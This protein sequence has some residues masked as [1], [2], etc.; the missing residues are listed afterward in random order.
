MKLNVSKNLRAALMSAA[1]AVSATAPSFAAVIPWGITY[2]EGCQYATVGG[3]NL[4]DF[5]VSGAWNNA[6]S[7]VFSAD[8][9]SLT[10]TLNLLGVKLDASSLA[11]GVTMADGSLKLSV[12]GNKDGTDS[13]SPEPVD[14]SSRGNITFVLSRANSNNNG[15]LS[16]KV[17]DSA[18]F[19]KVLYELESNNAQNSASGSW[20]GVVFGGKGSYGVSTGVSFEENAGSYHLTKAGY[21]YEANASFADL[22]NYY[23]GTARDNS[24]TW[25][26]SGGNNWSDASWTTEGGTSGQ[27]ITNYDSVTFDTAGASVEL[28]GTTSVTAATVSED[29]AFNLHGHRLA[30]DSL[31]VGSGKALTVS[32]GGTLAVLNSVS[33]GTIDA[34]ASSV[35]FRGAEIADTTIKGELTLTGASAV[36]LNGTVTFD[37]VVNDLTYDRN[38]YAFTSNTNVVALKFTG[39]SDLTRNSNGAA[40]NISKILLN[41]N[42]SLTVASGASLK[43]SAIFNQYNYDSDDNG[44]LTVEAGGRLELVGGGDTKPNS[45]VKWLVNEGAISSTQDFGSHE[46]IV[47]NGSL[48]VKNLYIYNSN[49]TTSTLGG[50]V[51]ATILELHGGTANVTGTVKATNHLAL[52]NGTTANVTG[53]MTVGY[54]AVNSGTATLSGD[55]NGKLIINYADD[56][57]TAHADLSGSFGIE[58]TGGVAQTFSGHTSGYSGKIDISAGTLN[59]LQMGANSKVTEITISGGS[60]LGLYKNTDHTATTANE[61]TVTFGHTDDAPARGGIL[62]VK[63]GGGN[64]NAN[65]VLNVGSILDMDAALNL[66]SSL[67]LNGTTLT[68]GLLNRLV[69]GPGSFTLFSGVDELYIGDSGVNRAG[70]DF[71]FNPD[72]VKAAFALSDE[73]ASLFAPDSETG[74]PAITINYVADGG[75]ITMSSNVPEPA[76]A[77][78]SLL[79]LAALCARRRRK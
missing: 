50:E 62:A 57:N 13:P 38:S 63:E 33:G 67:T 19:S 78:L 31:T 23:Y 69:S 55:A 66:G 18:D 70:S 29:T 77:T 3:D 8:A 27:S 54:V 6:W 11:E 51:N 1:L 16:L 34:T 61:T 9:S 64:L 52:Y 20:K 59:L 56:A 49:S 37:S 73:V 74:E 46:N 58:K 44:S 5:S 30:A 53:E 40:N 2:D 21:T 45:C 60:T 14:F 15:N 4:L 25:D 22:V 32:G 48:T 7:I 41:G 75:L 12:A 17:Y 24:L 26:G 76:T 65:V 36:A 35:E 42:S 39:T 10:G 28:S 79:A 72:E 71:T 43:A 47:N 68:G